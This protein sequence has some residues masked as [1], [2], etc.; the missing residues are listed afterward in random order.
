MSPPAEGMPDGNIQYWAPPPPPPGMYGYYAGPTPL[1]PHPGHADR[2]SPPQ[3]PFYPAPMAYGPGNLP[4]PDVARMIPCRFY[5]ACRYGA[6]CMFAHPQSAPNG[7]FYPPP[8]QSLGHYGSYDPAQH[9]GAYGLPYYPQPGGP[10]H[11]GPVPG[12]V[13]IP[14]SP[15]HIDPSSPLASGPTPPV[16]HNG[17]LSPAQTGFAPMQMHAPNGYPMPMAAPYPVPPSGPPPPAHY[18]APPGSNPAFVAHQPSAEHVPQPVSHN[19]PAH[20]RRPSTR[21][22]SFVNSRKP[23]C[24]FFP[25]GRCKNG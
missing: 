2:M 20:Q 16:M 15:P 25:S 12:D 19:G 3:M 18:Q 9:A 8:P 17:P 4:P 22:P 24:I 7:A 23:P 14:M 5:P 10:Y 21:R 11:P 13:S 6:T 1:P